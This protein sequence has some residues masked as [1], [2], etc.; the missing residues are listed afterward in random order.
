MEQAK[1]PT[2]KDLARESGVSLGTVSKVI[3]GLPVGEEC[4]L[5]VEEAIAK[6]DYRINTFAKGFRSGKTM[7]VALI[8]PNLTSPFFSWLANS[9]G[10]ELASRKYRMLLFCTNNALEQ[11]QEFVRLAEQQKVDGVICLG[12]RSDLAVPEGVRF[13][14]VDRSLR[15]EIP[16]VSSDNYAGG[17][18]AAQKLAEFGCTRPAMLCSGSAVPNEPAKRRDGFVSACASLGLP[19]EIRSLDDGDPYQGFEDFLTEH[20]HDGSLDFDGLFCVTDSLAHQAL[21]SLRQ[22]GLRVPEDVQVIGFDGCRHFGDL[23]LTCSTIVQPVREIAAACV[24]R[25]LQEEKTLSPSLV[26]LPVSFAPGGT[27]KE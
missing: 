3:N 5:R 24:E 20:Y 2:M 1:K 12:F 6:L 8:L 14:S 18:L 11:E 4:R 19:V 13:V 16:C 10:N 22:L 25:L 7:M 27:T 23:D 15:P 26:C 21:D 17:W 9:I